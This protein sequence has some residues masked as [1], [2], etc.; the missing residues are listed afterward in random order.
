V[1]RIQAQRPS[2]SIAVVSA[3]FGQL[4][5]LPAN[6]V[7]PARPR[8]P[9]WLI[10][11]SLAYESSRLSTTDSLTSGNGQAGYG[12]VTL[13]Y[14]AGP[15]L[16]ASA[17]FGGAG[18]FSLSRTITLPGFASVAKGSPNTANIGALF[19]AS[20]TIGEEDFYLR[21]S[22]TL[23]A[24]N[25]RAGAYRENGGGV[26]NLRMN[27]ASQTT[28]IASPM[29]ELG[30]RVALS[31]DLLLRPFV[32]VGVALLSNDSWR[33]SGQLISAPNGVGAFSTSVPMDQ[34]VGRIGVGAQLYTSRNIDFRLQYDGE[35]SRTVTSHAGSLVVS[36][37]F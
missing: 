21:P 4:R 18:Q 19:R 11:G 2:V 26:L 23:S 9:G 15:W 6:A 5:A 27:A 12:A 16:F 3:N 17:A 1:T 7:D 25:V 37:P 20:Y 28:L 14:Q 13:K 22:L 10:G 34:A 35:F 33:Q 8:A 24:V 29:L 31:D 30:G 36:M 32:T